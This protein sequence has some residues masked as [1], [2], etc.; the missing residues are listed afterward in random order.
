MNID[1]KGF[2]KSIPGLGR[3]AIRIANILWGWFDDFKGKYF[4]T[5]FHGDRIYQSIVLMCIDHF[6]VSA[7]V[8]TGTYYG[9]TTG[10][11]A[12]HKRNLPVYSTEIKK[13]FY[14]SAKKSLRHYR[15]VTIINQ[16][17]EQCLPR[18]IGGSKLGSP[19]LF[20]LDAHWYDYWPLEDEVRIITSSLEKAIIVIDDFQV[21][22]R[23][24]FEWTHGGDGS[25]Q[26]KG[27]TTIDDR[28]CN[29]DLI[30]PI[31]DSRHSYCLLYPAYSCREAFGKAGNLTG[32]VVI[33]QNLD[34][35]Q[36]SFLGKGFIKQHFT[37]KL[38]RAQKESHD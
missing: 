25:T 13:K 7:F 17:S 12:S 28:P 1:I 18:L 38:M 36:S 33:L 4:S 32:Y 14:N 22:G 20:Y 35:E 31:M 30:N 37:W 9:I 27:R 3:L 5:P 19:P 10:F 23:D 16:S 34:S 11:V 2:I 6:K 21:P 8:E 29:L 15:N 24:D 26:F